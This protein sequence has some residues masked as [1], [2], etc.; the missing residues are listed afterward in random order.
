MASAIT[1]Y[2]VADDYV[3]FN[4]STG[5]SNSESY[6]ATVRECEGYVQMLMEINNMGDLMRSAMT[7]ALINP[8]VRSSPPPV[9]IVGHL[10]FNHFVGENVV[11][12]K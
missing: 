11:F 10:N 9:D 1:P 2:Y 12:Q 7:K 3:Y 6:R 4:F 5:S 8:Q